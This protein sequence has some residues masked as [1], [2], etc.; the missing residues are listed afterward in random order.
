MGWFFPNYIH[1]IP[2]I[3]ASKRV[4]IAASFIINWQHSLTYFNW[5]GFFTIL[6]CLSHVW[7][8]G[9]DGL[10]TKRSLLLLG[11]THQGGHPRCFQL[12]ANAKNVPS[13]A[14]NFSN[15]IKV[16]HNYMYLTI[17]SGSNKQRQYFKLP[18]WTCIYRKNA[19]KCVHRS[20]QYHCFALQQF[21]KKTM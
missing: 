12:A 3:L 8:T 10:N 9:L 19:L 4:S 16:M 20:D 2:L 18:K 13:H 7:Q 15:T 14:I 5:K 21:Q 1:F 17:L 11:T 6:A